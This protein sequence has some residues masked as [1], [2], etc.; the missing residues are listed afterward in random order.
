MKDKKKILFLSPPNP[1]LEN[2]RA[3]PRIGL[4]YLGT[5]LQKVGHD[6]TIWHLESLKELEK[7]D[8]TLDFIGISATTREYPDA[9]QIL[10]YLKREGHSAIIA[11]GGAHATALPAECKRNGFD[12]VVVGEADDTIE[13]IVQLKPI[14]PVIINC[15]FVE[16]L[17]HIPFPDR[18]LL[19]ERFEP[20]LHLEGESNVQIASI[21]LSRGCPYCCAFCAPHFQYRRRSNPNIEEEL[22]ILSKQGYSA[23]MILDD[24][25]FINE[26][27]VETFCNLI[28]PLQMKFRCNFRPDLIT[29]KVVKLLVGAGCCRIQIGIESATNNILNAMKKGTQANSNGQVIA[30][31]HEHG[32]QVK[33]LFIWGLPSDNLETADAIVDWVKTYRPNSIQVSSFVPLP[34]S[35]LWND[36]YHR[37]VTNYSA[38]SFFGNRS[39]TSVISGIEN[40]QFSAEELWILRE[41]ILSRCAQFTHIDL[42]KIDIKPVF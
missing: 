29:E 36:R 31:C 7:I 20:F 27:Q 32:I 16:K 9:V 8:S 2:P 17:D 5:I 26:T 23:L 21:L 34:G 41:K 14:P 22:N 13:Q 39:A 28:R 12:I 25:P 38:L 15:G 35:P 33:A 42:G 18:T 40:D 37:K 24:L 10:N 6:V 11:I 3:T 1:F 4:L 19:K 30:I